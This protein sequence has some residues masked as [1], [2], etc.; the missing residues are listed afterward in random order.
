MMARE[1]S[2][3]ECD[4]WWMRAV[5]AYPEY[6]EYQKKTSRQIPLFVLEPA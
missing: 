6:A 4:Q 2:G 5:E 3:A 1:V